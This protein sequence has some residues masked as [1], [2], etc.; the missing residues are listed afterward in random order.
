VAPTVQQVRLAIWIRRWAKEWG[1][2]I[3]LQ[4]VTNNFTALDIVG[5]ASR[6]LMREV[7]GKSMSTTEFPSFA[8]RV[9][10][11]MSEF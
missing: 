7:T 5:P 6:D 11:S 8:F 9:S 10:F 3:R 1:M 2:D 4:D